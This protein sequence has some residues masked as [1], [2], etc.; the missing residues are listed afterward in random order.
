MKNAWLI[1]VVL[2]FVTGGV[3]HWVANMYYISA[4]LLAKLNS[5]FINIASSLYG[6]TY[7][8]SLSI[9]GFLLNN[10]VP[11]TFGNIVGG[12][13]SIGLSM[14][15]INTHFNLTKKRQKNMMYVL[16][17]LKI[18]SIEFSVVLFITVFFYLIDR[19]NT[20][21]NN[22]IYH[23]SVYYVRPAV[24]THQNPRSWFHL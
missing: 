4:G 17:T 15:Y 3:K 21:T 13:L 1:F 22:V 23:I 6:I 8:S 2:P 7:L 18:L 11:V 19:K 10:L 16:I 9:K 12:S 5:D 14:Y 20:I 24:V